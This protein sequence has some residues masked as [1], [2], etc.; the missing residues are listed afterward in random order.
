MRRSVGEV[1]Q[2]IQQQNKNA[3]NDHDIKDVKSDGN[4][5]KNIISSL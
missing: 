3:L 4:F 5:F 2:I 1:S